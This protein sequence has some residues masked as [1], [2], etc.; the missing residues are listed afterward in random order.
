M[1]GQHV[2]LSLNLGD[3]NAGFDIQRRDL[4]FS[5]VHIH[6]VDSAISAIPAVPSKVAHIATIEAWSFRFAWLVSLD[7][8]DLILG[9]VVFIMLNDVSSWLMP[10]VKP[11]VEAVIREFR[12]SYVHWNWHVIVLSGCV[13]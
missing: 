1:R 4:V 12:T 13:G 11:I 10:T 3:I 9:Y 8:M 2:D 6:V 5:F 7:C